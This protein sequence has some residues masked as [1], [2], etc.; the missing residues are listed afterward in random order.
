MIVFRF[1]ITIWHTTC[2]PIKFLAFSVLVSTMIQYSFRLI[3]LDAF[4]LSYAHVCSRNV[5][6]K[7]GRKEYYR[8]K[9]DFFFP[10]SRLPHQKVVIGWWRIKLIHRIRFFLMNKDAQSCKCGKYLTLSSLL[11]HH[12]LFYIVLSVYD[13]LLVYETPLSLSLKETHRS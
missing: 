4:L 13:A 11:E 10:H 6:R 1:S 3:F 12:S 5:S 7:I 8:S 9:D 2:F